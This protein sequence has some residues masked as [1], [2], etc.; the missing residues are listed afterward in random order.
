[1]TLIR[2][3]TRVSEILG[4]VATQPLG[5][6]AKEIAQAL[7]LPLPTAYHL[8]GTLVSE[9]LLTKDS[10]RRYQLGPQLGVLTDAY[11]R[12]FTPPDHLVAPL[13]RLAA[14]TGEAAYIAT[15]RN[16]RIA[17]LASV[18]GQNAVRVSGVHVGFVEAAHARASGK[19]LLAFAPEPVRHAYLLAHPLTRVTDKTLVDRERFVLAL[20][21]VR[22]DGFAVDDEE[23]REGVA[24]A[25]APVLADGSLVVAYSL[26]A[27]AELFRRHR[28]S[29]IEHLLEAAADASRVAV[30]ATQ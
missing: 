7:E 16:D 1:V 4:H 27:P 30:P 18:E 17:V 21:E 20:E 5:A 3:V 25:S 9:G 15:W 23:F 6:T 13:H 14:A 29:L 8:L 28:E 26:S 11:A 24:C 12:Q 10:Q 22:R 19:V 2:S